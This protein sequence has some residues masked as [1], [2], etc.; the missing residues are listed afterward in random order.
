M[1]SVEGVR[2]TSPDFNRIH[3]DTCKRSRYDWIPFQPMLLP[4]TGASNSE[5]GTDRMGPFMPELDTLRGM[6]VLGVLF[7]H[8]FWQYAHLSFGRAARTLLNLTQPGWSGV[9]LFFFCPGS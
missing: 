7:L 3:G 9:N 4:A 5:R 6:A 8:G 2:K 1:F